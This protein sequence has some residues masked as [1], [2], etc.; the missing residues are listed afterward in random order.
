MKFKLTESVELYYSNLEFEVS[1][2]NYD[3]STGTYGDKTVSKDFEY[4]ADE[5]DVIEFLMTILEEIDPITYYKLSECSD[6]EFNEY[7]DKNLDQLVEKYYEQLLDHFE[8][9]A[10][11]KA[12]ENYYD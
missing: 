10:K 5:D 2:G 9:K 11:A 8:D 3:W 6:K 12:A 4:N 1:D 7:F